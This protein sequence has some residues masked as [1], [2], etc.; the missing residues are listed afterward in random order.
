MERSGE[1]SII[2]RADL[3]K[4][5]SV[6]L[7][8]LLKW[9]QVSK[10]SMKLENPTLVLS[11]KSD[12]K[13]QILC[14]CPSNIAIIKYWG[15]HG[16]QLPRNPSI[17]FTLNNAYT[18]TLLTYSAKENFDNKIDLSFY[19]EGKENETFKAKQ[20]KFLNSLLPIFP[21]LT[22][23]HI[24]IESHNSFPHSA[25]IASSAS[26]MATLAM[27]L[28]TLE[29]QLFHS[30]TEGS[31]KFLKK[32]SYIAR[33]GSG[34]A[35]RSL[36]PK[37]AV[38]GTLPD[39]EGSSDEYA[40]PFEQEMHDVFKTFH[41]DI[42]IASKG[43]KS[44]SSRMGHGLMDNNPFAEPRYAQAR[45]RMSTLL[46]ALKSGDVETFG[47]ICEDEAMTLHAL[48]MTNSP[49]FTLLKPNTLKMIEILRGYREDTKLPIYFSLDAGPNLHL[50]YPQAVE[51]DVKNLID[52]ELRQ[53]CEGG[54][55]IFDHV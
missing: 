3:K 24:T 8:Q 19:F 20:V 34:S 25:G 14:K 44:V 52:N 6:I 12:K 27:C 1:F 45:S 28:C 32:A 11:K 15:K 22:Q 43:E 5:L 41:D 54:Q 35:C 2:L 33:L 29:V 10:I 16:V 36:Y 50:L 21:F 26:S 38:W 31:D 39:V 48:M 4:K 53:Y 9:N 30:D 17:S 55:V 46:S 7:A 49:W 13:G 47:Q 40:V 23:L 18:E 37:M 42:L 51:N